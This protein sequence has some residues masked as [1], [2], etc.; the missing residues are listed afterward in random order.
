MNGFPN[1]SL[2]TKVGLN[3]GSYGLVVVVV[4]CLVVSAGVTGCWKTTVNSTDLPYAEV[5]LM[6]E[7]SK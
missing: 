1:L 2:G 5:Q 6:R 4:S 3:D 7:M